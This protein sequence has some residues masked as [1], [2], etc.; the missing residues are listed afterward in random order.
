MTSI[1]LTFIIVLVIYLHI[2]AEFKK[3]NILDI[4]ESDYT[5]NDQLQETCKI[6]QPF[7]FL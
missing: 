6:K 4:Y 5:S 7:I 1:I 3:S 2:T